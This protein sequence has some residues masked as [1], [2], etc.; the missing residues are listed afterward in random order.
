MI[1]LA[2]RLFSSTLALGGWTLA[3]LS[4]HVVRTPDKI[5]V[6]TKQRL[7]FVDTYCDTR[8]WTLADIPRH[9]TL[10]RRL[11]EIDQA[12]LLKNATDPHSWDNTTTQLNQALQDASPSDAGFAGGAASIALPF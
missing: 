2:F 9:P 10:V 11:I 7:G 5:E 8:A 4:L 1:K 12:E 6:V 3:A